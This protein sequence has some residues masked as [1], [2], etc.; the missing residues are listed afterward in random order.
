VRT[1][2]DWMREF[3]ALSARAERERRV[4]NAA[5]PANYFCTSSDD[6]MRRTCTS[7]EQPRRLRRYRTRF[8][9]DPRK[10]ADRRGDRHAVDDAR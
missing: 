3:D 8:G 4:A 7:A 5:F 1:A 2:D 10:T 9:V 6:R